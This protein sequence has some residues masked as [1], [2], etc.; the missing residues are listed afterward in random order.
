M[1]NNYKYDKNADRHSFDINNLDLGIINSIR[2]V[3]LSE[4]PVIAFYGEEHP[5]INILYNN[6]PLHNEYMIHRI[7]LIP[8]H[9]KENIVEK[10]EDDDYTFELNKENNNPDIKMLDVTTA[11]FTGTYKDKQLSQKELNELF[12][13]NPITKNNILI[14]RLRLNEKIHL[15]ANAIKRT[16]KLNSSFSPVSLSNFFFVIDEL[17]ANKTDNILDKERS[18]FKDNYGEPSKINFQIESINGFSYKYLFNKAMEILIDKLENLI[19]KLDNKEI[20]I[21]EVPNI[22]NSFNFKINDEDDTLG[23]LIQ[24]ILHNKYIREK[25]KFNDLHC[26]Y[27]GYICPH[28]LIKQLLIRFTLSTTDKNLFYNFFS[29][30][31]REIIKIINDIKIEWGKFSK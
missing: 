16:A 6:T 19:L 2:R 17:E 20:E 26:D 15:K 29:Q 22:P 21:E 9:I 23:N 11:D 31:C 18:Y 8:L 13:P 24:S 27:V 30:N 10:Y 25:S 7:G 12:P 1:F 3:I 14:T 5:T 28:P 4:I